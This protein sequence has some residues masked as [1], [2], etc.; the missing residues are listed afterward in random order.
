MPYKRD[1]GMKFTDHKIQSPLANVSG[2]CQVCHRES[3]AKLMAN[4]VERQDKVIELRRIAEKNL[5]RV[6]VEAKVAWDNGATEQEM[7]PI[8]QL[9]RHAQWRWDWVGAANGFGFHSPVEALRVMGTS[10]QKSNEA[11]ILLTEILV[12]RGVKTPIQMPDISSKA[13]AQEYIGLDMPALYENKRLFIKTVVPEWTRIA[14]E[15]EAQ[16]PA[17]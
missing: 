5:A 8:L 15:R 1:G 6:H 11:R 7:A 10:I 14:A 12:R 3:E 13:K 17:L 9:I 2:S 4:V 16:L